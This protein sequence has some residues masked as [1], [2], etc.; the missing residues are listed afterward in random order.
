[1][2]NEL[3][4]INKNTRRSKFSHRFFTCPCFVNVDQKGLTDTSAIVQE[5]W[6]LHK[7]MIVLKKQKSF[8]WQD[9]RLQ[10]QNFTPLSFNDHT[11]LNANGLDHVLKNFTSSAIYI[12]RNVYLSQ[13]NQ[14]NYII[15]LKKPN[16]TI[17]N[18]KICMCTPCGLHSQFHLA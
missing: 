18:L 4:R 15:I 17:I 16:N 10:F 8:C 1:M 14:M 2:L 5:H 11:I 9:L 6:H 3:P 13:V 7:N 12:L